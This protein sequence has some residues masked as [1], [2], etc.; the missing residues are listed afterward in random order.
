[1]IGEIIAIGD[2]LTSGRIVN[3]TSGFAARQLFAAGHEIFAMHTIGDT[4]ELIG[5]ALLR[6]IRRVDFVIVTG[7]LGSTTD[8]L[9]NEAVS[10]A[11][12]RPPTLYQE[13]LDKIRS[14]NSGNT[15][16]LEKL[17][18]L[19]RGARV[20]NSEARIAGYMLVH[21]FT[22]IFFL[23]GIPHQMKSLLI[24]QVI[25]RLTSWI[26]SN[27]NHVRLRIYKVF[28]LQENEVNQ[29]IGPLEKI[30]GVKI[31]YYPVDSEVHVSLTVIHR[32]GAKSDSLFM[33]AENVILKSLDLY[34]YGIDQET[35][36]SAIGRL[37]VDAKMKLSI[38]ESCTGGLISSK[39]TDVAG[40]SNWYRGGVVAYSN[41]LKEKLLNVDRKL[42]EEH[43]AVSWQVAQ[44]MASGIARCTG[45]D[46]AV[47]V[48]GIAGPTGGSEEK[49]IGTVYLGLSVLG[50]MTD[51]CFRFYGNRNQ[52]QEITAITALDEIRRVLLKMQ[53][54]KNDSVS[55]E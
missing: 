6:A 35:M 41:D 4:P 19:P 16:N 36:A 2:E 45:S 10:E 34:I 26:T 27:R 29:L 14:S 13:I 53:G 54:D 8:D 24:D 7:G 52:I 25:P 37:L 15:C 22:P 48:T 12:D 9:T 33:E 39:I 20:L 40:S 49:P 43:G 21:N 11:L 44:A 18:W 5:E 28:G 32:D 46:I 23:P 17:A 38:A 47:S 30:P 55:E 3:T 1:M 42:L 51:K 31:G 50:N